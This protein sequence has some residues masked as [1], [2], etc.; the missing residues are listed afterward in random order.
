VPD[1]IAPVSPGVGTNV[2]VSVLTRPDGTLVDRQRMVVASDTSTTFAGVAAVSNGALATD[3][4]DV[5]LLL[6]VLIREVRLLRRSF[7]AW[8]DRDQAGLED[9]N[10]PFDP[11]AVL[12]SGSE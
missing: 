5:R 8:T 1:G 9:T 10:N 11:D 12:F 6:R 4:V 2:D 7:E 3:D